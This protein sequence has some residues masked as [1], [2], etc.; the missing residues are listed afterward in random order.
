[1]PA[2]DSVSQPTA[3][4]QVADSPW[5][6]LAL[7]STVALVALVAVHQKYSKRQL[8]LEARYENRLKAQA[9]RAEGSISED[10]PQPVELPVSARRAAPKATL[11]PLLALFGVGALAGYTG[12][13]LAFRRHQQQGRETGE[14]R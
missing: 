3:E 5:F 2:A 8:R 6:W 4:F 9:A 14:H 12:L 13:I 1:M 10:G 7:F 11:I